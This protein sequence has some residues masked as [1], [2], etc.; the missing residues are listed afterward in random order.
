MTTAIM[1][2]GE[3]GGVPAPSSYS[4][5]SWVGLGQVLMG[6][7]VPVVTLGGTLAIDIIALALQGFGALLLTCVVILGVVDCISAKIKTKLRGS[8]ASGKAERSKSNPRAKSESES[9]ANSELAA[10][11]AEV[12]SDI[13]KDDPDY[14]TDNVR[15]SEVRVIA[16]HNGLK[17]EEHMVPTEDGHILLTHRVF[18]PKL[19]GSK[20]FL[21]VLCAHGVLTG[22]GVLIAGSKRSLAVHLAKAGLDVWLMNSRATYPL[23]KFLSAKDPRFWDWGLDELGHFDVPAA[24]SF[25]K[26]TTSHAKVAY[27]GHSQGAAQAFVALQS[28]PLLAND[29]SVL[30]GLAPAVFVHPPPQWIVKHL[31]AR[32]NVT[33][34]RILFGHQSFIPLMLTIQRYS[35]AAFFGNLAYLVFNYLFSWNDNRWQRWRRPTYFQFTPV[36]VS[37][38][39]VGH[40]FTNLRNGRLC[41]LRTPVNYSKAISSDEVDSVTALENYQFRNVNCNVAIFHA[42]NDSLVDSQSLAKA[43]KEQSTGKIIHYTDLEGYSHMDVVWAKDAPQRVFSPIVQL[44]SQ[45]SE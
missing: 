9:P 33:L 4:G 35:S 17:Y 43:I 25:I 36:A 39:L 30:V 41:K 11:E 7:A 3:N 6:T 12:E 5:P 16:E 23:H 42:G 13:A 29:I 40:W 26:Q 27:I 18:D 21:P 38:R 10:P 31:L 14:G 2:V 32:M 1:G 24:I 22:A 19:A 15:T 8:S 20:S 37:S 28:H 44:I 34:V 45:G